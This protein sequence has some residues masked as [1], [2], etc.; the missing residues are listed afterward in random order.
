MIS[1]IEMM[2][3]RLNE[4]M[5]VAERDFRQS[6][7]Q[8][9][10]PFP[11]QAVQAVREALE[12][13]YPETVSWLRT[14]RLSAADVAQMMAYFLMSQASLLFS[15][16]LELVLDQSFTAAATS[17]GTLLFGVHPLF[18]RNFS[19]NPFFG[20]KPDDEYNKQGEPQSF[21][22]DLVYDLTL[23]KPTFEHKLAKTLAARRLF[24]DDPKAQAFQPDVVFW[25]DQDGEIRYPVFDPAFLAALLIHEMMHIGLDHFGDVAKRFGFRVL[26]FLRRGRGASRYRELVAE[27]QRQTRELLPQ[28]ITGKALIDDR[29]KQMAVDNLEYQFVHVISNQAFDAVIHE[30]L[31]VVEQIITEGFKRRLFPQDN[32]A[33]AGRGQSVGTPIEGSGESKDGNELNGTSETGESNGQQPMR[34]VI[35]QGESR[36]EYLMKSDSLQDQ[37][38]ERIEEMSKSIGS[39]PSPLLEKVRQTLLQL[40][41]D[42]LMEYIKSRQLVEALFGSPKVRGSQFRSDEILLRRRGKIDYLPRMQRRPAV[43]TALVVVDTSGSM[44][45]REIG[46]AFGFLN[47]CLRKHQYQFTV[48]AC[49]AAPV[50]VGRKLVKLPTEIHVPRGGTALG[51]AVRAADEAGDLKNVH[52]VVFLTDAFNDDWAAD[53]L[54]ERGLTTLVITTQNET[55]AGL[56]RLKEQ[57]GDQVAILPI[58]SLAGDSNGHV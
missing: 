2:Q 22:Y 27:R 28:T 44:S 45:S 51:Q 1:E 33:G 36:R 35:Q 39:N 18:V 41:R 11:S 26:D 17:T 25:L 5:D 54:K 9:M 37:I 52:A 8:L 24:E 23:D 12:T 7:D 6:F 57:L 46:L 15:L 32:E 16:R 50:L 56:Q 3:Q 20:V 43:R 42:P 58:Q 48:Y 4:L 10:S 55:Y 31:P 14:Q 30:L 49:D 53:L 38:L 40:R 19:E 13:Y 29:I 21:F 47:A 34:R